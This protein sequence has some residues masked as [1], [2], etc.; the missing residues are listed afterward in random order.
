MFRLEPMDEATYAAWR[1]ES[2]RDYGAEKVQA[3]NWRAED[4]ERLAREAFDALLPNGRETAGHEIRAMV[5]DGEKVGHTWWTIEDREAGRVAF[6]YDIAV[7]PDHRRRGYARLAL[8]EVE[9]WA[10]EHGCA[11]VML[12]VFGYNTPARE[13]YR[14]AGFEETNVMMVKRVETTP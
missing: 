10:A 13:L 7:D 1:A 2:Q 11:G 5:S 8:A 12:H 4:A 14:S 6:I 9:A 3:G